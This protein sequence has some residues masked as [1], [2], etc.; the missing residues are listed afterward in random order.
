[1]RLLREKRG[2]WKPRR[3]AR[4]K[5]VPEVEIND[6]IYFHSKTFVTIYL[7]VFIYHDNK[8][9]NQVRNEEGK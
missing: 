1:M 7:R 9:D 3:T 5:R 4:G 6:Q 2:Q 8:A